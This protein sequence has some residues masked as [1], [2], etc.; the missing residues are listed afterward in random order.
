MPQIIATVKFEFEIQE[1]IKE[2]QQRIR[3]LIS[4]DGNEYYQADDKRAQLKRWEIVGWK[5]IE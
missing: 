5:L 1:P 2:A 4:S 3:E